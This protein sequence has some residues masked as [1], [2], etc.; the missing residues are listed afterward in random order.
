MPSQIMTKRIKEFTYLSPKTVEEAASALKKHGGKAQ[1]LA[2]GTDL[3]SAMK[4]GAIS[5]EYVVNIKNIQGLNKVR[6]EGNTLKIGALTTIS[7]I[8]ES[9]LIKQKCP[10]L[11]EATKT[12]ATPQVRN[13]ATIG[14]NI[15]RSSPAGDM[16]PPLLTFNAEVKLVGPNGE[17]KVALEDFLTGPWKNVLKDEILTEIIVPLP[18]EARGTAFAKMTRNTSDLAKLSCAVSIAV[19]NGS[20]EDIRIALGSLADKPVRAKKV[21]Q[22]MKGKEIKEEVIKEAAGKVAGDIS[23]ITDARSTTEYRAQVS[24]VLVKRVI[25]QASARAK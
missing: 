13:M 18:K 1:V 3:L 4:L 25:L 7:T 15:C 24:Q 11:H 17:R 22:A 12:F 16:I 6:E 9:K 23:P 8:Q 19:R 14:G 10:S 20:C 2:G 21:E 5:P